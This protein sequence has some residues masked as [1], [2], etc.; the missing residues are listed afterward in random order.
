MDT[1][2]FPKDF[3]WGTATS[4]YQVE[5]A[6]NEDGRGPSIWDT[7]SRIPDKVFNGQTG[8]V[9]SDQYHRYK[10]DIALMKQLG[11][12]AYRFSIAWPR[13]F[14]AGSGQKNEKGFAYYD[15]LIDALL[16]ANIQPAVTL[17]HWD[18]PQTLQDAGGWPIRNT[19]YCFTDYAKACFD[20]YGDRVPFWYTL[21]EPPCAAFL[22]YEDG[23]HAPGIKDRQKAF[24]TSHHLL[25]AHGLA[26]QVFRSGNSTGQ[27]GI[28]T[29]Y[30]AARPASDKEED[31]L[32]TEKYRDKWGRLFLDA[33]HG[34]G[35][36]QQLLN[37]N[38]NIKLPIEEGDMQQIAQKIDFLGINNYTEDTIQHSSD[39]PDGWKIITTD[40]PKTQMGWDITPQGMYNILKFIDAE[41]DHPTI[42]I[43][44][45]GCAMDDHLSE[46]GNSCHDPD[47][48][49]YQNRYIE[50]CANAMCEGVN[51]KGYFCWS[52]IDNF[53]WAHGY[54]KRFGLVYCD[55]P[56]QKRI[57]KDSFYAYRDLIKSAT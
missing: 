22:G 20:R 5:G 56:T 37:D 13:L 27:I 11:A 50:A 12:S 29:N 14:P 51:I 44:E 45:S 32:A 55:Y 31:K 4:S 46:D 52:F 19:A 17:Y 53:E 34:S 2:I 48:I 18:L 10:E 8:D 9:A 57:P 30:P 42:Y 47:R 36:P 35:Y 28:A 15:R 40:R 41:Y 1:S 16:E 49:D 39:T 21:N 33:I 26:V 24:S 3:I 43:T 54:T 23:Y 7:F 25:L 38:P 6:A